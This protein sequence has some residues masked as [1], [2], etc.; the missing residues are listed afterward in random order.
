VNVPIGIWT[1]KQSLWFNQNAGSLEQAMEMESR[2]VFMAQ[3]TEDAV[4][5]RKSFFEKRQ[6]KFN[7]K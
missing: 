7:Y 2:A 6:P 4:E 5:K 1:T 3:S